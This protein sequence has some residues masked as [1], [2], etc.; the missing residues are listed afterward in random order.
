MEQLD[1]LITKEK[2]KPIKAV[3]AAGGRLL[4]EM[5]TTQEILGTILT[6]KN[7]AGH[8]QAPQG[9]IIDVGPTVPTEY[10]FEVGQRV[11]LQGKYIPIPSVPGFTR[12]LGIVEA[13]DI[14]AIIVEE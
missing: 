6:V 13:S 7:H 10:A 12:E 9:Y 8:G 2:V 4:V 5:L 11:I 3:K 1:V 14:K